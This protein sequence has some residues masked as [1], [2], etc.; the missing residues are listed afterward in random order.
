MKRR[1][2]RLFFYSLVVLFAV[3]G[4]LI[5]AYSFGY[6]YDVT[7]ARFRQNGGIFIKSKI[8]GISVFLDGAFVRETGLIVGSTL[9]TDVP[10]AFHLVRLE[11]QG[12]RAWSKVVKVD[13]A[14]VTEL[15]SV[16]LV[17][18]PVPLATATP[19]EIA[20][21]S[22]TTTAPIVL[23][24]D[25]NGNLIQSIGAARQLIAANVHSYGI[26]AGIVFF[27]D[28][29]GFFARYDTLARTTDTIGRP[30]FYLTLRPLQFIPSPS[31]NIVAILDSSGG[32]F[33]FQD[34]TREIHPITGGIR[35]I[36]FDSRE[37]KLL[38]QKERGI[39]ILFLK[40]NK[41][42]PFEKAGFIENL[43]TTEHAVKES[44]WFYRDDAHIAF[45]TADG[46]FFTEIDARGGRN[47]TELVADT[48]SNLMT[49]RAIPNAIFFRK[50]K[51]TYKIEL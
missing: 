36:A 5:V 49:S 29:N 24:Q 12:Y 47:T 20:E 18:S 34:S 31:G 17:P 42:Q 37:E 23:S 30:G 10:P 2:R 38:M 19:E 44:A 6:T 46:I 28:K 21:V 22:A 50:G 45:R 9:L 14:L 4:P 15:R 27:V 41:F 7:R 40:E 26:A 35:A 11:K 51:A 16:M 25:H 1:T 32:L 43:L 8:S 33:I 3:A 13:P 39:D 48:A